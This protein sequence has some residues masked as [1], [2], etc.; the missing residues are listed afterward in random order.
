[1]RLKTRFFPV[2][3]PLPLFPEAAHIAA[4]PPTLSPKSAPMRITML[5]AL[6]TLTAFACA[7]AAEAPPASPGADPALAAQETAAAETAGPEAAAQAAADVWLARVDAGDYAASWEGGSAV[8]RQAV[9]AAQWEQAL[10]Q[11]RQ[12]LGEL[13][14]RRLLQADHSTQLPGAPPGEYVA[15]VFRTTFAAGA[16]N[17]QLVMMLDEDGEW[18]PVGYFVQP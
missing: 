10:A 15:L 13:R 18:R 16:A 9:T 12:P 6:L 4:S 1:M 3:H 2:P 5:T 11:A 8:F 14:E 7:P 17:E